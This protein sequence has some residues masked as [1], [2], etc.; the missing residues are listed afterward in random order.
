MPTSNWGP[1]TWRALHVVCA[2]VNTDDPRVIGALW[3]AWCGVLREL[4]CPVC[5]HH[6]AEYLGSVSRP[7]RNKLELNVVFWKFHNHVNRRL[8]KRSLSVAEA[9]AWVARAP[10]AQRLVMDF[11]NRYQMRAGGRNMLHSQTRR[12]RL[13]NLLHALGAHKGAFTWRR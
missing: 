9:Q 12:A 3:R 13:T 5:S 6:A 1:A 4:P 10:A 2:A 7:P 8:G 11:C